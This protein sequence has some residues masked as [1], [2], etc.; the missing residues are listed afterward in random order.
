MWE[1]FQAQAYFQQRALYSG[2][3]YKLIYP[4]KSDAEILQLLT[5]G[6]DA[7][8]KSYLKEDGTTDPQRL[9]EAF[10]EVR[11]CDQQY[12][13]GITEIP[14]TLYRAAKLDN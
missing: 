11:V 5:E 14:E 6:A 13:H 3:I 4:E 1:N 2:R 8:V 12:G 10:S 9:M 7:K